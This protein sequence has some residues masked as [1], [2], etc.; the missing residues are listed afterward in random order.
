MSE[1]QCR[2]ELGD[3]VVKRDLITVADGEDIYASLYILDRNYH[4]MTAIAHDR[5]EYFD[6]TRRKAKALEADKEDLRELEQV[7]K[8]VSSRKG[9]TDVA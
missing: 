9:K 7:A 1:S 8:Q 6:A 2:G 4:A 3:I 5:Y